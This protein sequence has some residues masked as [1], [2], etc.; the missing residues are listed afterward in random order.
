MIRSWESKGIKEKR[1]FLRRMIQQI[2]ALPGR[3]TIDQ[4]IQITPVA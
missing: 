4:R 2:D 3:G 1:N